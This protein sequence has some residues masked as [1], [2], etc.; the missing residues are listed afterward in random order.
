MKEDFFISDFISPAV[1]Y[2]TKSHLSSYSL[3]CDNNLFQYYLL[4]FDLNPREQ[5]GYEEIYEMEYDRSEKSDQTEGNGKHNEPIPASNVRHEK[6]KMMIRAPSMAGGV[7][8]MQ[9]TPAQIKAA[10]PIDLLDRDESKSNDDDASEDGE[11]R[12]WSAVEEEE[13]DQND[14]GTRRQSPP[15]WAPGSGPNKQMFLFFAKLK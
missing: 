13:E 12:R 15:P 11:P 14:D 9:T 7:G 8:G 2:R 6:T 4:Q 10:K 3:L 5:N 1:L